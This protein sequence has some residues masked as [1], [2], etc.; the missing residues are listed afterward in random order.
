M[1]NR[2]DDGLGA[3]AGRVVCGVFVGK[4]NGLLQRR[5][6]PGG[7]DALEDEA[8]LAA[9]DDGKRSANELRAARDDGNVQLLDVLRKRKQLGADDGCDF[10]DAAAGTNFRAG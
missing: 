10:R 2:H 8:P 4:R 6:V 7:H 1:P 9:R 3:Y 5:H